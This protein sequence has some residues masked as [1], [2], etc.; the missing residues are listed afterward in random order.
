M[1]RIFISAAIAALI[2]AEGE[3]DSKKTDA[4][5]EVKA[6]LEDPKFDDFKPNWSE[7]QKAMDDAVAALATESSKIVYDPALATAKEEA[8]A[9][10]ETYLTIEGTECT[11]DGF[12]DGKKVYT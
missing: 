12:T 8:E 6:N 1:K 3:D 2:K 9:A 10:L 11:L 5:D 4:T 7:A